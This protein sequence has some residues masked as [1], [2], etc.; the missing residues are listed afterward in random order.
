MNDRGHELSIANCADLASLHALLFPEL[1][2]R[3]S[4]C[5]YWMSTGLQTKEIASLMFVVPRVVQRMMKSSADKVK[6][7]WWRWPEKYLPSPISRLSTKAN[8]RDKPSTDGHFV[9]FKCVITI[10]I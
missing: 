8:Y 6:C 10:K 9:S 4:E 2:A 7:K 1:T 3:E 5:L